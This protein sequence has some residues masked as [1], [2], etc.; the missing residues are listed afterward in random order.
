MQKAMKGFTLIELMITVVI[1][2]I[3]ATIIY[4]TYTQY[5]VKGNRSAAESYMLQL[6]SREEQYLADS[7]TYSNSLTT[8]G[9]P[10][11]AETVGKYNFSISVATLSTDAGYLPGVALPQYIITATPVGGGPQTADGILVLSSD[12]NKSPAGKWK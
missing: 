8:L 6:A 4:P 9:R 12:G 10:Q 7:K 1:I 5:V 2:S 3:L 11:P